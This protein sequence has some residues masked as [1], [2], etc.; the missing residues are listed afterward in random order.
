[1]TSPQDNSLEL[2][3]VLA[4]AYNWITAHPMRH[5]REYGMNL[6]EF[7]VLDLLYH[8]GP[9]PL[10]RIGVK[11]LISSGNITYVV[12]KLERKGLLKRNPSDKDRRVIFAEITDRGRAFM[13]DVFPRHAE[14]IRYAMSGLNHEEKEM[15]VR[16]LK[17]LGH[18]AQ[19]RFE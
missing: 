18:A 9:Q 8:Q 7:G 15:A 12:D 16:L 4:R 11:I 10:Q 6:T 5:V 2:F 14:V 17:K 13:D 3:I 19:E 1:M